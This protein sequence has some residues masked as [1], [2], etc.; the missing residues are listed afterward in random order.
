MGGAYL[1][2]AKEEHV[3]TAIK[4]FPGDGVDER[5]Q[6]LLTSVNFSCEEWDATYGEIYRALIDQGTLT[7]MVGHIAMPAYEEKFDNRPC[8]RIIPA[9]LSKNLVQHLLREQLGFEGLIV[10]DATPMVEFL[11]CGGAQKSGSNDD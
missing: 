1:Q 10:T 3:A 6:H 9:T 11:L 5:D 7:V 8:T 2:A 4:H